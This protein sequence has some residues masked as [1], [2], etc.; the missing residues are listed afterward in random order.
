MTTSAQQRDDAKIV[1]AAI[2]L[3]N[4]DRIDELNALLRSAHDPGVLV[5]Y[6]IGMLDGILELEAEQ[7]GMSFDEILQD[8]ALRGQQVIDRMA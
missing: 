2:R 4:D 6:M 7:R 8:I 1:F 3:H 5:C